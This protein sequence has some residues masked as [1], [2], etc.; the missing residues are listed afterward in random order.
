M[1]ELRA[2]V[3]DST[4]E[5]IWESETALEGTGLRISFLQEVKATRTVKA[6]QIY[7]F[8]TLAI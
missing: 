1:P 6:M 3:A 8:I 5:K 2:V 4:D 7:F